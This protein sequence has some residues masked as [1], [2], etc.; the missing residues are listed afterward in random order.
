MDSCWE[1]EHFLQHQQQNYLQEGHSRTA[2]G[3]TCSSSSSS[4]GMQ[5]QQAAEATRS[6]K[7]QQADMRSILCAARH[8]LESAPSF[9][10]CP[11]RPRPSST[12]TNEMKK[13][14]KALL[15][16]NSRR[17][18]RLGILSSSYLH[19]SYLENRT[20]DKK[21]RTHLVRWRNEY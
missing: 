9:F 20:N 10:R 6:M 15:V 14:D 13:S 4:R 3:H 5:L 12:T 21:S 18:N 19:P 1:N 11:L 16:S 8:P 7:H 2:A 17:P